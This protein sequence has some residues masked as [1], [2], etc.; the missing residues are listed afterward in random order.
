MDVQENV[1]HNEVTT[2]SDANF[3]SNQLASTP[4]TDIERLD[5]VHSIV[6]FLKRPTQLWSGTLTTANMKPM[7][8]IASVS[9]F[10][11]QPVVKTFSLPYDILSFGK[12]LDKINNFEWLKTDMYLRF[13]VNANPFVAGRL[14][15]CIA[16]Q[17]LELV[18]QVQCFNKARAAIT[19]YPGVELDLQTNTACEIK[20][21]WANTL[22]ALSITRDTY[23][24][25][26]VYVFAITPLMTSLTG[27]D[28][29]AIPIQ[30]FG[31]LDN[32]ELKGPTPYSAKLQ[33]A[34]A[35]AKGPI[36]EVSGVIKNVA[37]VLAPLPVVGSVA[38]TVSWVSGAVNK[39]A[40]IFGWSRPVSGSN[41]SPMVNIPGR[42]FTQFKAEDSS[43]ML[44]MANDNEIG[45]KHMNFL[46][47]VDEMSFEHMCSRP[48][49]IGSVQWANN[50]MTNAMIANQSVSPDLDVA[51]VN[52]WTIGSEAWRV[53]DSTIFENCASLFN[54]WRA[55]IH[56]RVSVVRTPFHVGR[57]E[58]FFVPGR[59]VDEI[60]VPGLDATNSYRHILDITEDHELEFVIPYMH[61]QT[62][63][64]VSKYK[65]P[66]EDN[67]TI[68]SFV[69]RALT[70]LNCPDTVSSYVVVN[71]WKWA[72]NVAF[73]CPIVQ[74]L[75][76]PP[77]T[78]GKRSVASSIG[79]DMQTYE[80]D[81]Q[82]NVQNGTKTP[83]T[84]AFGQSNDTQSVLDAGTTTCG[85]IAFNL[86]AATRAHRLYPFGL[87]QDYLMST[88]LAGGVGGFIGFAANSFA[89]W[90]GGLSFK[91][92]QDNLTNAGR[93]IVDTT[94]VRVL[95]VSPLKV[96]SMGGPTHRTYT[97]LN[98]VHE[99][100]APFY[101]KARRGLC[102]ASVFTDA[103]TSTAAIPAVRVQSTADLGLRCL[104][105][106]KDDLTFGFLIGQPILGTPV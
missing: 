31:W 88:N 48:G 2:F 18:P 87:T 80:A 89:F 10:T 16:P 94:L 53:F 40:S 33:I 84:V 56:Y 93:N 23:K 22:D 42:G 71:V 35:E 96:A 28:S 13:I 54:D 36:T 92:M 81:L 72:T 25:I 103:V 15:I 24:K 85:E 41:A 52:V 98:P 95:S 60:D 106:G 50:A 90:R 45:E 49:L 102:N 47:D 1:S 70:P 34:G 65:F 44:A 4:Y 6:Q 76:A 38:S 21:P 32:I 7:W 73:A 78:V 99:V 29:V 3:V 17:D 27:G 74:E 63:C 104:I 61:K 83:I 5:D 46:E 51:R 37:D 64:T 58:V 77:Y 20:V 68:G 9:G 55:D 91:F 14:W 75:S 26:Q 86:R 79:L 39:V 59:T 82:L 62:F 101:S 11:N 30:C 105:G 43:V 97:D 66:D 100:Q 19:S 57:L 67:G 69:I 12:K 8:T